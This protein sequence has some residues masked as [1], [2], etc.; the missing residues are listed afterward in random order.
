MRLRWFRGSSKIMQGGH[1]RAVT[2][3]PHCL[4]PVLFFPLRSLSLLA[5]PAVPRNALA[6]MRLLVAKSCCCCC[7]VPCKHVVLSLDK[8]VWF[9]SAVIGTCDSHGST[10][11]AL[12]GRHFLSDEHVFF[13]TWHCTCSRKPSPLQLCLLST[14]HPFFLQCLQEFYWVG[15][16]LCMVFP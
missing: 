16:K 4:L 1:G 11:H 8:Q 7:T 6:F 3:K 10:A 13:A 12:R 2:P 15:Q 5:V 14:P 9:A